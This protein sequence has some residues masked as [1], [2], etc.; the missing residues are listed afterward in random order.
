MKIFELFNA[1]AK[2]KF[3]DNSETDAV[4]D[5]EVNDVQ[6]ELTLW[7][8]GQY[9]NWRVEFE[10]LSVAPNNRY[11]ITGQGNA[12]TVFATV[13]DILKKFK[14][15]RDVYTM[16]FIAEEPNR[17]SLY[18]RIVKTVFP[19]WSITENGNI[20]VVEQKGTYNEG[21][22]KHLAIDREFDRQNSSGPAPTVPAENKPKTQLDYYLTIN[23]KPWSDF[24][25]ENEA[26]RAAN[27]IYNK[28]PRLRVNVLPRIK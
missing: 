10:N 24:N 26:L 28:N 21:K 5:F 13:C 17:K 27:S 20:I 9:G 22:V 1:P 8:C 25:T 18:K 16:S 11:G 23:G 14:S 7:T 15:R 12:S 3:A 19:G 4:I 2:W 6:Y